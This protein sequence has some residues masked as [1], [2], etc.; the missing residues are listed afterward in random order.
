MRF[1]ATHGWGSLSVVVGVPRHSRLRTPGAVPR[2]S[3]LESAGGGGVWSLAA[4]GCRSW[5]RFPAAPGWGPRVAVGCF[6]GVGRVPCCVCLWCGWLP[7]LVML[8]CVSVCL[9]CLCGWWCGVFVWCR[10]AFRLRWC[11]CLR[12]RGVSVVCGCLS[13]PLSVGACGWCLCGC[14][15]CVLWV[16]RPSWLR[17]LGALPRHSWLRTVVLWCRLVPR[18]SWLRIVVAVPRNSWLGSTG[19]GGRG[20]LATTRCGAQGRPSPWPWCVCACCVAPRVGVGGVRGSC[21]VCLRCVSVCACGVWFVGYVLPGSVCVVGRHGETQKE[22][23]CGCVAE[24]C[25]AHTYR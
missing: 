10:C 12:V 13:L 5:L 8:F 16:P 4:P 20:S 3:W 23:S 14:G 17:V 11:A 7:V 2:H 25:V 9:W 18:H 15:S 6:V 22:R 21:V 19:C 24:M 1:P